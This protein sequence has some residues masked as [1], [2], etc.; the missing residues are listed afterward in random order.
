[1]DIWDQLD[2]ARFRAYHQQTNG[3]LLR[4]L[5]E[6]VPSL[7]GTTIESV[8]LEAKHKE[9]CERIIKTI[10]SILQDNQQTDD[11]SSGNYS[12]M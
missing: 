4:H 6:Q 5:R 3:K 8:A 9:G 1:M 10:E 11:S 2:S 7:L 12:A